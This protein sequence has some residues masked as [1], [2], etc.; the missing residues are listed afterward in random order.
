M[1]Q[2]K[3][4]ACG[5]DLPED[6]MFCPGC[7]SQI[8]DGIDTEQGATMQEE[9]EQEQAS[10]MGNECVETPQGK[11]DSQE[12]TVSPEEVAASEKNARKKS[13]RKPI[14]IAVVSVVIVVIIA[15]IAWYLVDQHNKQIWEQEHQ[16]YSV[17][18]AV[19]AKG[20][21]PATSTPIPVHIEGTDFEG[22]TVSEDHLIGDQ[23]TESL[24]FMRGTYSLTVVSS[25]I[26][27]DGTV[28]SL[29]DTAATFEIADGA[30]SNSGDADSSSNTDGTS[31]DNANNAN[32]DSSPETNSASGSSDGTS[33]AVGIGIT[34]EPMDPLSVTNEYIE[35]IATALINAGMDEPSVQQFKDAAMAKVQQ[36]AEEQRKQEIT[37]K[38]KELEAEYTE[39][40]N[41]VLELDPYGGQTAENE[42]AKKVYGMWDSLMNKVYDY[43]ASNLS[44]ADATQ[45][46]TEQA[47]WEDYRNAEMEESRKG[48]MGSS[49]TPSYVYSTGANVTQERTRALLDQLQ[50]LA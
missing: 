14:I 46:A 36:A 19:S 26:T 33:T 21:D 29:P 5:E 50:T 10:Q 15:F 25:P 44:E 35:S 43:L 32:D 12:E 45:L 30:V 3:C 7:G 34:L 2:R 11:T 27:G 20:Y 9:T 42:G 17:N 8:S 48:G 38:L 1:N 39:Q 24:S 4:P 6:A 31:E 28:Y 37:S 13:L 22:N 49:F 40:D 18:I 47:D 41:Y 23:S 16:E